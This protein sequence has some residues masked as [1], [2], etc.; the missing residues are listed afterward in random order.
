[1]LEYCCVVLMLVLMSYTLVFF[2]V[3]KYIARV[4]LYLE[5]VFFPFV[6]ALFMVRTSAV[7]GAYVVFNSIV[8]YD[9]I[10]NSLMSHSIR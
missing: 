6:L 7:G 1:M 4:L 8:L 3:E 9:M 10:P 5:Y 2:Y